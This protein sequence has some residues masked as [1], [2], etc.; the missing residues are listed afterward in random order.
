MIDSRRQSTANS[1]PPIIRARP[2]RLKYHQQMKAPVIT[3]MPQ[4]A[5][6]TSAFRQVAA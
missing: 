3:V 2:K 5:G 6:A 1:T 4:Y